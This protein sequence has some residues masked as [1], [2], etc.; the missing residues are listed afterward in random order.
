MK[1]IKPHQCETDAAVEVTDFLVFSRSDFAWAEK[2]LADDPSVKVCIEKSGRNN[3]A[4][5]KFTSYCRAK[6]YKILSRTTDEND[7][8]DAATFTLYRMETKWLGIVKLAMSLEDVVLVYKDLERILS[9]WGTIRS[10]RKMRN[11]I[12]LAAGLPPE[13]RDERL[14]CI[15]DY[16]WLSEEKWKAKYPATDEATP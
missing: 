13:E 5:R 4:R 8:G 11:D 3:A 9:E 7:Y 15:L 6:R 16:Y 2:A 1:R 12:R 14:M 10:K